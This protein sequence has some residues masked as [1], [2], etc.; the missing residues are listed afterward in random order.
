MRVQFT[1]V[2]C[3]LFVCACAGIAQA[4]SYDA[5]VTPNVIYGTGNANGGFTVDQ[6]NGVELGL[7]T[8]LRYDANGQPQNI[9]N[10]NGDGTYT[11]SAGV[12]PMQ[13]YPVGVWSFDWSINTNYDGS[14]GYTAL[15]DLTYTLTITSNNGT[16]FY[17]DASGFDPVNGINP[18]SG[19]ALWDN[20]LGNNTTL[21]DAGI[22]L[23][24]SYTP[25]NLSSYTTAISTYNVAQNSWQPQWFSDNFNPNL[26]GMYYIT[27]TASTR[28][29]T[30]QQVASTSITVDVVPV[31][32]ATWLALPLL[33]VLG[34][35]EW[36][37]RRR[38]NSALN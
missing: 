26:P 5:D 13:T 12:A 15:D 32:A 9:Y 10:S 18:K 28:S 1:I 37:R 38:M 24:D 34:V 19:Y 4:L 27:L 6:E 17:G 7:R 20:A 14:S 21:A 22:S 29:N 31:P 36:R 33:G 25:G 2:L 16:T 35:V 23:D 11:F 3:A 8:H 30:P